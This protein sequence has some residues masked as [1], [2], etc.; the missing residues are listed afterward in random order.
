MVFSSLWIEIASVLV[1]A[2]QLYENNGYKK[3]TDL[4]TPRCDRVYVK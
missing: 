3:A 2:V 4:E 1:E